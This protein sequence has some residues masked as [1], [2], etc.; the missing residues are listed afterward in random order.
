M[1]I[2]IDHR[3]TYT[4]SEPAPYGVQELRLI[5]QTNRCQ[6]VVEWNVD[7]PGGQTAGRYNDANGN[8]VM[9][10][11]Q[12]QPRSEL[13]ITVTGI[14]ESMA[15]DGVLGTISNEPR[16]NL[17]IRQ[18]PLTAPGRKTSRIAA[19][20]ADADAGNVA[21]YHDIMHSIRE[22]MAFDPGQTH[23]TT[24]GEEALAAGHGVCQ[25]F[26]HIFIATCRLLGRPAR[27]VTGY[28]LMD[29]TGEV[30]DAHHAWAEVEVPG[31]GWVGFDPANGISPDER[32]VRLASGHDADY[33]APVRGIR[34]GPGSET[35]S[36][37]VSAGADTQQ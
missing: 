29:E 18:T 31:L 21:C 6:K 32:Y 17:Y 37:E 26:A 7:I 30:A 25:D 36:V 1:R 35:L 9:L 16:P 13:V 4:Y 14:V 8:A 12:T 33:A 34:R 19:T 2:S 10:V 11:N 23:A 24:T 22:A 5:P 15:S 20:F 3:T 28:L 27:Y